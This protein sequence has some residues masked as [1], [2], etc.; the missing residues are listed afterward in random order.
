M[1]RLGRLIGPAPSS[2]AAPQQVQ[3]DRQG[4]EQVDIASQRVGWADGNGG[5]R[6]DDGQVDEGLGAV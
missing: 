6:Q 2:P 4:A 1:P 3:S 5:Q